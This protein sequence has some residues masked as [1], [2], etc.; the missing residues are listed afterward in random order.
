[1]GGA[2]V[3]IK[4]ISS[5]PIPHQSKPAVSYVGQ[6]LSNTDDSVL[7]RLMTLQFS[8]IAVVPNISPSYASELVT[9]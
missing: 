5:T 2:S 3:H 9:I 7:E 1:M 8:T 6:Y 4:A